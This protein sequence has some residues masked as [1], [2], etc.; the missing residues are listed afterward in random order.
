MLPPGKFSWYSPV[1]TLSSAASSVFNSLSS[2][3][4]L[5]H[6]P[7]SVMEV[8]QMLQSPDVDTKDLVKKVKM[9]PFIATNILS[10]ANN[11]KS[12]RDPHDKHKI[13]SLEHAL[14]YVGK[15]ALIDHVTAIS[16]K[17]FTTTCKVFKIDQYW[18]ESF[19][20]G[21]I[22]EALCSH[23]NI[24]VNLDEV[25]LSASLCNVGKF[26]GA[27]CLPDIV[28]SVEAMIN[29]PRTL[30]TWQAAEKM[31]KTPDHCIL[32]EI[33]SSLWGLPPYIL[34]AVLG[35]HSI[36]PRDKKNDTSTLRSTEIVAL[37]NQ[38]SHWVLLRP[39]RID[40]DL[41]EN[42][43]KLANISKKDLDDLGDAL[44]PIAKRV[45]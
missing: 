40:Q 18:N 24:K 5:P 9:D 22:A 11:L 37:A 12:N 28:D 45:A 15:K 27:I 38:M 32:G 2:L 13:D 19:L 35:H 7:A 43:C 1:K 44:A 29:N 8:Q 42:L 36:R 21:N 39:S 14:V 20:A 17:T 4:S 25:F 6:I 33:G 30:R 31:L 3:E 16:L 23:L 10:L 26:V 41:L 34:E